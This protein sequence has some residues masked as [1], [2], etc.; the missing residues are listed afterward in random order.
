MFAVL[1]HIDAYAPEEDSDEDESSTES[2]AENAGDISAGKP[3]ANGASGFD[4]EAD[5]PGIISLW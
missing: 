1:T 2:S 4:R 5:M 3:P